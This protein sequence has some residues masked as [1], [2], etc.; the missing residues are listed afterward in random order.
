MSNPPNTQFIIYQTE[1]GKTKLNVSFQDENIWLI[2][3]HMAELF[4]TS[5]DN[6]SL[7]L[8][9]I[10]A[11]GELKETA[12]TEDFSAVRQEGSRLVKR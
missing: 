5:S 9:N 1:D 3:N 10:F 7:H 2:Q 4:Q 6:S 12:T 11:D 8:K